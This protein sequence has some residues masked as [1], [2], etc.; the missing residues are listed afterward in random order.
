MAFAVLPAYAAEAK[1]D[2]A[3]K[4]KAPSGP[5]MEIQKDVIGLTV[6]DDG[7]MLFSEDEKIKI[8]T[9]DGAKKYSKIMRFYTSEEQKVKIKYANAIKS[10]GTK[11]N[12]LT[13][14][15][16]IS[17]MPFEPLKNS[18]L[19]QNLRTVVID[20]GAIEPGDVVE[21]G[22]DIKDLKPYPGKSFWLTSMSQDSGF[23]KSSTAYLTCP[24][25]RDVKYALAHSSKMK[26]DFRKKTSGSESTYTYSV[27][28]VPAAKELLASLPLSATLPKVLFSCM[29]SWNEV[30]SLVNSLSMEGADVGEAA[31]K[32]LKIIE[33]ESV[34][35]DI[36]EKIYNLVRHSKTVIPSGLGLGGYRFHKASDIY[37]Q[38]TITASDS[39]FLIYCLLRHEGFDARLALLP[40]I[41][42]GKVEKSVPTPQQFDLIAVVLKDE[43]GDL[44]WIDPSFKNPYFGCLPSDVQ[45]CEAFIVD[46]AQGYFASTP[47]D[48]FNDNR[49]EVSSE[50]FLLKDGSGDAVVSLDFYGA[51]AVSWSDLYSKLNEL[52]KK[53]LFKI[54]ASRTAPNANVV[55]TSLS[56]PRNAGDPFSVF[57]R[58]YTFG[59]LKKTADGKFSCPLPL[60]AGGDF[61]KLIS[62]GLS[63]R[64]EPVF[65]GN[66]CQEDRRFRIIIPEGTDIVSYPE[67]RFVENEVGSFQL[68]TKRIE[69]GL[70]YHSRFIVRKNVVDKADFDKLE[71]ILKE[72]DK[73]RTENMLMTGFVAR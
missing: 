45:G 66:A 22:I 72:A 32:D 42:I 48:K 23:M 53:N 39:A 26:P 27:K 15:E 71:A 58:F 31:V 57:V 36:P 3:A 63:K 33:S 55:N 38:N 6:S 14:P 49:E 28:N 7:T 34:R 35:K 61:R 59:M 24:S 60:L 43:K 46:G 67:S 40:S 25:D 73:A 12:V 8:L 4:E 19:Y 41:G 65:V 30:A 47:I 9:Q 70:F 50:V 44:T 52:Q 10:N 11:V 20:F 5:A 13:S 1:D 62:E 68:I 56:L 69:G 17:A 64:E 16:G 37:S 21:Y 2:G 54:I 18:P 51:N 29:S